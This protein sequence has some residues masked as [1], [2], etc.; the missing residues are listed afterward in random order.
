MLQAY[1]IEGGKLLP[2]SGDSTALAGAFWIDVCEPTPEEQ[3][4]VEQALHVKLGVPEEPARFKSRARYG[5]PK[6]TL[7]SRHCCS[8]GWTSIGRSWSPWPSSR[9]RDSRAS[10]ARGTGAVTACRARRAPSWRVLGAAARG[11]SRSGRH[12]S[13]LAARRRWSVMRGQGKTRARAAVL[14][15]DDR[16]SQRPVA[17]RVH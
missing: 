14:D 8:P 12:R 11:C 3:N 17:R 2:V 4:A 5:C 13:G 1:T 16:I 15:D 7:R 10:A 9:G 6:A